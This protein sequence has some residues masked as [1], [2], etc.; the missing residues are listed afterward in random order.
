MSERFL[1]AAMALAIA[2]PAR[3]G[4]QSVAQRIANAPD[5]VLTM[6]YA[7]REG[8]CGDGNSLHISTFGHDDDP[9]PRNCQRGP[10]HVRLTLERGRVT[11]VDSKVGGKGWPAPG[12]DLGTVPAADAASALLSIARSAEAEPARDAIQALALADSII[13]WPDLLELARDR[14][15]PSEPR[16][17]ALFWVGQEAGARVTSEMTRFVEDTSEDRELRQMAVF[18]LSRHPP[19]Q[20]VPVLIRVARTDRDPELRRHAIFFLGRTGDPRAI[21]FFE[22]VLTR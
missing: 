4:A 19:D 17:A 1:M 15:R 18:A 2:L 3:A 6:Q 14:S 13:V 16:G 8:V 10:V 11:D 7:A 9:H 12:T 22:E 20:S 5:G 21:D